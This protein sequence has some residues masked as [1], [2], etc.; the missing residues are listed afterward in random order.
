M[1]QI[2]KFIPYYWILQVMQKWRVVIYGINYDLIFF[3]HIVSIITHI[4]FY[5]HEYSLAVVQIKLVFQTFFTEDVVF[6][7]DS[8]FFMPVDKM[9]FF[10]WVVVKCSHFSEEYM[11]IIFNDWLVSSACWSAM[12]EEMFGCIGWYI[13]SSVSLHYPFE[14]IQWSWQ[15]RQYIP[16]KCQNMSQYVVQKPSRKPPFDNKI[17]FLSFLDLINV[18][19]PTNQLN[20]G[21]LL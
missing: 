13:S 11:A 7:E 17:P 4:L 6:Y 20:G 3:A 8:K 15:W 21:K 5:T 19:S 14:T 2:V 10:F 9:A 16:P 12:G 1:W 18:A